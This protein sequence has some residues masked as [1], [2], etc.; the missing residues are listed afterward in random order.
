MD[1]KTISK[2][3]KAFISRVTIDL[4]VRHIILFGSFAKN[5]AEKESDIDLLVVGDFKENNINDPTG[6]L[7]DKYQDLK[8]SHELH[9]IG[10]NMDDYK[11]KNDSITLA[12][13][14]NT[15]KMIFSSKP[16]PQY[17]SK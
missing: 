13:I 1:Q 10:L 14:R 2:E 5:I 9:V 17:L 15:G 16:H 3:L 4:P 8:T 7:Y 11:N 12:S 6:T